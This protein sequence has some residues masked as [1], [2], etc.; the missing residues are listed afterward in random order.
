MQNESFKELIMKLG[1]NPKDKNYF[2]ALLQISKIKIHELRHKL[3]ML[4]SDHVQSKELG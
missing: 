4:G 2:E 3:K 1:V